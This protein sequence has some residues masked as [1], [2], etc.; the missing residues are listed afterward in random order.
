VAPPESRDPEA[1]APPAPRPAS[2]PA[3]DPEEERERVVAVLGSAER[4][5]EWEPPERVQAV[6]GLGSVVLDFRKA[7]L[8]PGLTEVDAWSV[9]GSVEIVVPRDLEVELNGFSLLG[10]LEHK[11]GKRSLRRRVRQWSGDEAP[12]RP[13]GDAPF[14]SVRGTAILGNVTVKVSD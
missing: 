5:G 6:A 8:P 4:R 12:A 13:A 2:E 14:L 3:F 10:S 9:M 11:S 1:P 7:D